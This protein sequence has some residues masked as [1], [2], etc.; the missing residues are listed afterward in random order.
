MTKFHFFLGGADA[1]MAE[2]K[3]I[4]IISKFLAV[5]Y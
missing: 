4:L 1:E 3:A 5:N 2:I